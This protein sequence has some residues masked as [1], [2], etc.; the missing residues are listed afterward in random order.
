M[1]KVAFRKVSQHIELPFFL[2]TLFA[3]AVLLL[4]MKAVAAPLLM[5]GAG[6]TFIEPAF[7]KWFSEYQ[8]E[9]S[10]VTVNYQGTGSG[11]GIKQ[12]IAGTV[13]FAATDAPMNEQ[14][15]KSAKGEVLH[16][17]M[18]MGAVVV[19]Y[20]LKLDK[21][22]NLSGAVVADIFAGKI[23][24]WNDAGIAK[25]NKGVKLP[26]TDI[27]V[28]TRSD[29]S[30]T[31]AVFSDYLSKVSADWKGKAGKTVDWFKGSLAAKGNAGVAGLIK[32]ADGAVGY[33]ELAYALEN[34]L[35]FS[36]IQN[37]KGEMVEASSKSVSLAAGGT[38]VDEMVKNNF[39]LSITDTD[40]K[41]GYPISSFSW[42]LIPTEGLA[43][44][45]AAELTKLAKWTLGAMPQGM[46]AAINYAALPEKLRVKALEKVSAKK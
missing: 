42:M 38:V 41:G 31:T 43:T 44:E 5:N 26:E 39:K 37:K 4:S 8:K 28:A 36:K 11:A 2:T 6:S 33:V 24:K 17:P 1:P 22:L 16:I 21:P 13:D 23:K 10:A 40:A 45:K 19:S 32:Q 3:V 35:P 12:L 15:V 29:G 30:G 14:E 27:V 9:N 7:T 18:V 20:N 25:L 34:K 46:L